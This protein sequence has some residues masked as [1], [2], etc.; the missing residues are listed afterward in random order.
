MMDVP[1]IALTDVSKI[2]RARGQRPAIHGVTTAIFRGE[3]IALV[4]QNGSGKST[5]LRLLLG[6]IEPTTGTITSSLPPQASLHWLPQDYRNA[7]LPW[8]S[9]GQN[10]QIAF[11]HHAAPPGLVRD[12]FEQ[13]TKLFR[14]EID[15]SRPVS[16]ASGG[17][18][19]LFLLARAL[20]GNP[21][22]LVL[23]EPLSAIDFARKQL[24][25]DYLGRALNDP[26]TTTI[27]ATHDFDDAVFLADRVL[28]LAK[29]VPGI[30][31]DIR[32]GLE[33]PRTKDMR[34]EEEF[35]RVLN[36]VTT[37]VLL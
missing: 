37:R 23:D 10:L 19:Q 35:K 3:R 30:Q 34:Q 2:F 32:V 33:W 4:G 18:L 22:L 24:I 1:L 25:R 6:L 7:L 5:L 20:V 21:E 26:S 16:R 13:I 27:I 12:A 11:R 31:A 29:D 17:E 28:V 15:L 36:A 14:F 8:F 9:F